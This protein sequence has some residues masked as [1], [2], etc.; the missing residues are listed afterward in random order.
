M[1]RTSPDLFGQL[2]DHNAGALTDKERKRLARALREKNGKKGHAWR[3]GTGPSGETCKTCEHYTIRSGHAAGSFR[4][5]GLMQKHWTNS[6][7][8]DIRAGDP[9]CKFWE[10][11]KP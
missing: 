8:T 11:A 5:C 3:P 9:A 10:K 6:Y 1:T 7:G 4:K 2:Q